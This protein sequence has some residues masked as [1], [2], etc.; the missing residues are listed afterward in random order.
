MKKHTALSKQVI[1]K[2]VNAEHHDPFQVLGMHP[3]GIDGLVVRTF[4]PAA[5]AVWLLTAGQDPERLSMHRIHRD[6]LF[7]AQLKDCTESFAYRLTV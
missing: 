2:I 5:Q 7:E 4:R 3:C 1:K 6:G